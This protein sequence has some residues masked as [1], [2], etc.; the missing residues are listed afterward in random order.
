MARCPGRWAPGG[1]GC[2]TRRN[3]CTGSPGEARE[4]RAR[5]LPRGLRC[6]PRGAG[7]V[8]A[9]G[10]RRRV[11]AAGLCARGQAAETQSA[12]VLSSGGDVVGRPGQP[13]GRC[14]GALGA[15]QGAERWR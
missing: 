8:A 3:P 6:R 11:G 2:G 12:R 14:S 1:E 9:V 10:R 5:F 7:L 15:V 13:L 4:G